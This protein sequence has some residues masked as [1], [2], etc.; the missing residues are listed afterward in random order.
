[1]SGATAYSSNR[2]AA[3]VF[4]EEHDPIFR[5]H[6]NVDRLILDGHWGAGRDLVVPDD[7]TKDRV[8]VFLRR[9]THE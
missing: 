3:A 1:V 8:A 4:T 7:V 6:T 5:Q 2:G 9:R